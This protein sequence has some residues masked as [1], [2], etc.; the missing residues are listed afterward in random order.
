ML[1]KHFLG[2]LQ[3]NFFC[4]FQKC[5]EYQLARKLCPV[6]KQFSN[7]FCLTPWWTIQTTWHCKN[8]LFIICIFINITFSLQG[9]RHSFK[10]AIKVIVSSVKLLFL[11]YLGQL[12]CTFWGCDSCSISTWKYLVKLLSPH[13]RPI[14]CSKIN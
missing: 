13:A 12:K 1:L 2:F 4:N 10:D 5:I 9:C 14:N 3:G 6:F 8:L 11:I 7:L